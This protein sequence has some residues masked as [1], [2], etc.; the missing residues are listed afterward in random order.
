MNRFRKRGLVI[1]GLNTDEKIETAKSY[2]QK[3]ALDGHR[4]E[5]T[6]SVS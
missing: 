5:T 6:V 2:L 4:P 3:K 1:I